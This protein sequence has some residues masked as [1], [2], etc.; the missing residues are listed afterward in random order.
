M[1]K[2]IGRK[3]DYTVDKYPLE[4]KVNLERE[5]D[6]MLNTLYFGQD[7]YS[8]AYGK[9]FQ[10]IN[11]FLKCPRATQQAL[12]DYCAQFLTSTPSPEKCQS[13]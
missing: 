4:E 9:V 5:K 12:K 6:L 2:R 1:L 7:R 3:L 13:R 11:F 10:V 8:P